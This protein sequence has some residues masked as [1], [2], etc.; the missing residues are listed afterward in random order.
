LNETLFIINP[1]AGFG[2][3]TRNWID[4]RRALT[5]CGLSFNEHVTSR[6]GEATEVTRE[7]LRSGITQVVAVGGDGTL[8]EVVNGYFDGSGQAVSTEGR[9][10]IM[11]SGTGSDF[12]RSV[13]IA[14]ASDSIRALK[15]GRHRIIDVA[16]VKFRGLDGIQVS[17]YYI[18]VA[19]FGL[20][21]D[22]AA[23]V[24]KWHGSLPRWIGGRTR[25]SA[26][27]VRALSHY[28]TTSATI[29]LDGDRKLEVE[30]HLLVVANGR[31]AGG[32]MMLAPDARLDDGLLDVII[33]DRATRFDVIM[34]L[35]RIRRGGYIKNPK[36]SQAK[37]RNISIEAADA[38]ALDVDGESVG[39]TPTTI[40][41]VP[42]CLHFAA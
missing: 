28:K 33:T 17:R 6:A 3:T 13:D 20:G 38:L 34:E 37:A 11:P 25:F 32:G 39:T 7:A 2:T 8:N 16:R 1:V 26:A 5:K 41:I 9:I 22:V 36:V 42:A 14:S 29:V 21:G 10:G 30:S 12:R 15:E 27:A 40:E 18:N 31:F 35:P 4:A 24:N 23:Y 19:S